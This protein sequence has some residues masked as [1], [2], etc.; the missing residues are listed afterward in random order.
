[1]PVVRVRPAASRRRDRDSVCLFRVA[2][3]RSGRGESPTVRSIGQ[4]TAATQLAAAPHRRAPRRRWWVRRW[5]ADQTAPT[6]QPR[7]PWPARCW[8]ARPERRTRRLVLIA[9][10]KGTF[11]L[12]ERQKLTTAAMN[13]RCPWLCASCAWAAA[14]PTAAAWLARGACCSGRW[15]AR[16]R[17]PRW[18]PW[19]ATAWMRSRSRRSCASRRIEGLIGRSKQ[20]TAVPFFC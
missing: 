14:P 1:M 2:N 12:A 20:G 18:T 4:P 19:P 3:G 17:R 6:R 10:S 16:T 5:P 8:K 9:A 11:K 13:S 15:L 7:W